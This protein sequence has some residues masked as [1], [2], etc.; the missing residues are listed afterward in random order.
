[1]DI[2]LII[3]SI[4]LLLSLFVAPPQLIKIIK[5]KKVE[6]ISIH[7]YSVLCI[8]MICYFFH[9]LSI[10]SWIFALSNGLNFIVNFFILILIWIYEV[11][12]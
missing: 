7:T 9:A 2:T 5:T 4:G 8:V 10:G 12:K 3:G 11:K 1:M 6:A